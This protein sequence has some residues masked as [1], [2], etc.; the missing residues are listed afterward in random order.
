M[1]LAR[2]PASAGRVAFDEAHCGSTV[3]K[4]AAV[5]VVSKIGQDERPLA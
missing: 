4:D 1:A 2:L 5:S 3:L